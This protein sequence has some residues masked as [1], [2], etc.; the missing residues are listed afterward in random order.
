[1][2]PYG[3]VF[4]RCCVLIKTP[5]ILSCGVG[6]LSASWVV[7]FWRCIWAAGLHKP[8]E[9]SGCCC[10]CCSLILVTVTNISGEIGLRLVRV[11]FERQ[12]LRPWP[13]LDLHAKLCFFCN[14]PFPPFVGASVVAMRG[15]RS[16]WLLC[17]CGMFKVSEEAVSTSKQ[18]E[19]C[20]GA[21]LA[22]LSCSATPGTNRSFKLWPAL[23]KSLER[24][25]AKLWEVFL[26]LAPQVTGW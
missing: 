15:P 17:L 10:C 24:Q 19:P 3:F 23:A 21:V 18:R 26:S 22:F 4:L 12:V 1:M 8:A 20:E 5:V 7:F 11:S 16:G 25:E 13:D 14:P 9:R 6:F 2:H